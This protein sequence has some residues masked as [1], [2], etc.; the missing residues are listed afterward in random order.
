MLAR[1]RQT[2]REPYGDRRQELI[3]LGDAA[4]LTSTTAMLNN[5]L[6]TEEEFGRP[7]REWLT[8]RDPFPAWDV[9]DEGER[10]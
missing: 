3:L 2:W 8:L 7:P 6:L 9:G 1:I 5:C 4:R 10:V